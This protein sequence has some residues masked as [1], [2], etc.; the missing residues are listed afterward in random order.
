MLAR[1]NLCQIDRVFSSVVDEDRHRT[2]FID[3]NMMQRLA[4][5]GK[6]LRKSEQVA[7]VVTRSY[8]KNVSYQCQ[9]FRQSPDPK[10]N[11]VTATVVQELAD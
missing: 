6:D 2:C 5:L 11:A 8:H 10:T 3:H 7:R 1:Q 9:D 4:H